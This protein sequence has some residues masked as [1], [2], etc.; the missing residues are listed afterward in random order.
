MDSAIIVMMTR[1][2]PNDLAGFIMRES[3]DDW[4]VLVIQGIDEDGNPIVWPGKWDEKYMENEKANLSKKD[5][6]ALYQQDPVAS[7]SNVFDMSNLKRFLM[8]DFERSDGILKKEDLH[9]GLFVDPAFSTSRSSDDAVVLC[10]GKHKISGDY[11][12][13]DGYADTSAP[14]KTFHAIISMYDRME[15]DGL[16]PSFV[17]VE[18]VAINREQ[19]KFLHDF[20]E[21]MKTNGRYVTVL[22]YS[23]KGKKE[24][25]IKFVLEPKVSLRAIRLRSDM[26]DRSFVSKLERQ[27]SEFPNGKHDDAIDCLAQACEVLDGKREADPNVREQKKTY[28]NRMTGKM[29]TVA[30]NDAFR[31]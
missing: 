5:W 24:D 30:G 20:R 21:Y 2:N 31:W 11:Y 3:S 1:W 26:A 18:D 15:S 12:L 19:S 28:F 6:A 16:K 22:P 8:S 14:S 13:L 4:D 23:P 7:S 17:S 29:E 27:F 9:V 25:R 10:V